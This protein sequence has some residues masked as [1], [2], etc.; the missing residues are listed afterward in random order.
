VQKRI[1]P[2]AVTAIAFF[3][4]F[5]WNCTKFD[6]TEIGSDLLPPVDNVNTFDT[7]LTINSTQGIF[8]DT[9]IISRTDDHALGVINNDPLFGQ[10]TANIF[11]QLK[12]S[13]YPFYFGKQ[14]DTLNGFGAGLDSVVLCLNYKGFWGDSTIPVHF[15]VREVN[16]AKFRDSV[17]IAKTVNYQPNYSGITIGSTDVDVRKLGDTVKYTNG[18]EFSIFQVRIKLNQAWALALYNKDTMPGHAFLSDSLYRLAYNGLAVIANAGGNGLLYSNLSESS[19]KLE[20]HFRR[21]NN[22]VIDSTYYSFKLNSSFSGSETNAPSNT[23]NNIIR[24]RMGPVLNPPPGEHYIQTAPG[25]YIDLSIPALSTLSNRI[26]HRA[27]IIIEQIPTDPLDKILTPPN[28]LYLDLKDSGTIARWKS[29]YKDLNPN[30]SYDPDFKAGPFLPFDVQGNINFDFSYYGGF[31]RDK[32]DLFGNQIK[33]YNFNISKYVQQIVTNHIPNYGLRLYAP[34][35]ITYP[36]HAAQN[37]PFSNN[38]AY[39]R[40]RIGSGSNPNYRM[41]LRIVYSKL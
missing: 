4:L 30:A 13:F 34:Y 15:E 27:E 6:T 29:I 37:F 22:G 39:G 11:M 24:N 12:P 23:T 14:N 38:I 36:Q 20:I 25:T 31:I 18:K 33:F 3:S 8:N 21:R 41:R 35:S 26:I 7:V 32:N 1:L 2:I 40:V 19:T 10:T 17:Y 5:G 28:F 16:D 9:T